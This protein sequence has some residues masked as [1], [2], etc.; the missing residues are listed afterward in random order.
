MTRIFPSF[1]Y[2]NAPRDGCWWDE[3]ATLSSHP[4]LTGDVSCDVAIVGAGFTG[5]SAAL[6]LARRGAQVVV[7]EA[8]SVGWGASGRN[9]G[10]CCLGGSMRSDAAF[11]RKYG[12]TARRAWRIAERSAV[13]RVDGLI[14]E[15]SMDVDRHSAGET[16]LAHRRRDFAGFGAEARAASENYGVDVDVLARAE[17][18]GAGLGGSFHGALTIPIGFGLNPRKLLTG[19][20]TAC[21][22]LGVKIHDDSPVSDVG[23]GRVRTARGAVSADHVII[24]TNGYSSEDIPA[25]MAGR[26]MPAQSTVIVTRPLTDAELQAQGWTSDQMAYDTRHLLH[27]FRLMPDRRFLFGMRGGLRASQSAEH[28][29]RTA[30]ARD[31]KAMFPAWSDVDVTHE[32]SGM[33]CLSRNRVPFV[34]PVPNMPGVLAGFAYHGNGVAMGVHAGALL[35]ALASGERPEHYP[36][37]MADPAARFP[38]GRQRR[39]V[40]P[41]IYAA[42][43]AAD[44]VP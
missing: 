5:L 17:L 39:L 9:G 26:Y 44:A 43:K 11:D 19:L 36:S 4:A 15:L 25:W 40:M 34:G 28:A 18:E 38:F 2:G 8:N 41:G 27:Y 12:V 33:V 21:T 29:A 16:C 10:F 30:V 23:A 14:R 32:W 31:F 20:V 42:F 3:T 35:A 7:L 37:V 24:A 1:A 6:H 22:A 13:E